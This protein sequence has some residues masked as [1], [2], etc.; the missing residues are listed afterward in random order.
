MKKITTASSDPIYLQYNAQIKIE[1]NT[2]N[3]TDGHNSATTH[4]KMNENLITWRGEHQYQTFE[5]NAS[6]IPI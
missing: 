5:G 4:T 3:L 6:E 1:Y 2:C